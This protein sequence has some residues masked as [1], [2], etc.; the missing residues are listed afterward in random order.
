[1]NSKNESLEESKNQ[2]INYFRVIWG[3]KWAVILIPLI[4]MITAK[5]TEQPIPE[6]YE[7]KASILIS[8]QG[9]RKPLS[10]ASFESIGFLPV[11]LQKT[12]DQLSLKMADGTS[13][14]Q[15]TLKNQLKTEIPGNL[16]LPVSPGFI[17]FIVRNS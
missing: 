3:W 7:T 1:M 9:S 5:L 16:A 10:K 2:E 14:N 17:F 4:A 13:M 15:T 8:G 6:I 11:I 12:I